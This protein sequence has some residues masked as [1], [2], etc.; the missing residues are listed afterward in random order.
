MGIST[1]YT[2][3]DAHSNRP[4]TGVE[5]SKLLAKIQY[6]STWKSKGYEEKTFD[7]CISEV[8]YVYYIIYYLPKVQQ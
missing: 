4:M 7:A 1:V 3:L 2:F 5:T 6:T 8:N